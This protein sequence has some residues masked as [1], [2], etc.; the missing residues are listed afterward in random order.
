M[1]R[2]KVSRYERYA[3]EDSPWVQKLTQ[4]ELATLLGYTK[5]QLE[6]LIRDKD[7]WIG[8][9]AEVIAG[10]KRNLAV[11]YGRLR[12]LHERLKFH[13]NKI[14]QPDY[15]FSP[16]KGKAQRDNAAHHVGQTQ[17]LTLDIRQFYPST[18]GEHIFRW[19]HHEAGLRPDV[20][21]MLV[22]LVAV[23]GK[24]PFGSPISPVLTALVHRPMFDAISGLCAERDLHM[25]LWVDDL[26]I[27]GREVGGDLIDQVRAI[28]RK[29]GFQTHKIRFKMGNRPVVVTGVPIDGS[30]VTAPRSVNE[31]VRIGYA[32]LRVAANDNERRQAI[33]ALL[34]AL[35]TYRYHMGRGTAEGRKAANRMDALRR[36][37]S[38]LSNSY[39]SPAEVELDSAS[40][41][42]AYDGEAP[43][44]E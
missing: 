5:D 43:P 22:H 36:R 19:A 11:P 12:G 33:D 34:S 37:R 18:T 39:R 10:K 30:R 27:S 1:K 4:K 6:A 3:F 35:G 28:M 20:A 41:A 38:A 42:A 15:L 25:S 13:L 23:D 16:R 7:K 44:W 40:E 29:A 32:N 14:R 17:F 8:R 24:M 2:R 9:R 21:G 26:T 31:R